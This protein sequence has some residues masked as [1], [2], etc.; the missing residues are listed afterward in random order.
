MIARSGPLRVTA[1]VSHRCEFQRLAPCIG[2]QRLHTFFTSHVDDGNCAS[3]CSQPNSLPAYGDPSQVVEAQMRSPLPFRGARHA[4]TRPEQGRNSKR[5]ARTAG[6]RTNGRNQSA[7]HREDALRQRSNGIPNGSPAPNCASGALPRLDAASDQ[8]RLQ[9]TPSLSRTPTHPASRSAPRCP[10]P[11]P[12]GQYQRG[13]QVLVFCRSPRPGLRSIVR[14]VLL[15]LISD[16][17][18]TEATC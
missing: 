7:A 1:P 5:C 17:S 16:V 6:L 9:S 2:I 15:V 13:L 10:N 14:Q 4:G 11:S 18:G 12:P 8:L 3:C